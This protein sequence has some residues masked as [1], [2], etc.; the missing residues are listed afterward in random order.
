MW[1]ARPDTKSSGFPSNAAPAD[2]GVAAVSILSP[3]VVG[4]AVK[5]R[6]CAYRSLA[7]PLW[8]PTGT[9]WISLARGGGD[10]KRGGC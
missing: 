9:A 10:G 7:R 2:F 3:I 5:G 4:E 8:Q 6:R 1:K